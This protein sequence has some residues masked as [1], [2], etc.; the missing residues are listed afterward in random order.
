MLAAVNWE[1]IQA[2]GGV[3]LRNPVMKRKLIK[4]RKV[5]GLT[6]VPSSGRPGTECRTG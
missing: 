5:M 2:V 6:P 4:D 1:N 3:I